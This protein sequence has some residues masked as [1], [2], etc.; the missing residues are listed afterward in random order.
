MP[1]NITVDRSLF[2]IFKDGKICTKYEDG[3]ETTTNEGTKRRRG[4]DDSREEEKTSKKIKKP[5]RTPIKEK[6]KMKEQN[7][8]SYKN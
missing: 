1:T 5:T 3:E 2:L 8:T 4:G 7:W 6:R